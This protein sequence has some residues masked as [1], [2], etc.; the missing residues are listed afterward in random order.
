VGVKK[1]HKR[2]YDAIFEKMDVER[3]K[4]L[5]IDDIDAYVSAARSYGIPGLVYKS[6]D[7]LWNVL[8]QNNI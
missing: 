1:P 4:V 2:I 3:E 6:P 8:R 7:D 5:Y